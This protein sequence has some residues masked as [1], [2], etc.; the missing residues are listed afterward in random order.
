MDDAHTAT[1][2]LVLD[3]FHRFLRHR[4]PHLNVVVAARHDPPLIWQ[5]LIGDGVG[6]RIGREDLVLTDAEVDRTLRQHGLLP[7][8]T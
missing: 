8:A 1:D 7:T 6:A 4:P 3:A 5:H 2:P